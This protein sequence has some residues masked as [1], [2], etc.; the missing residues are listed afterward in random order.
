MNHISQATDKERT[1]A[2]DDWIL[3]HVRGLC[4]EL[5]GCFLDEGCYF[6]ANVTRTNSS[7]PLCM[8]LCYSEGRYVATEIPS[9]CCV[10]D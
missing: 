5:E 6:K 9:V 7:C 8:Y 3:G 4:S 1:L 10:Q 2:T